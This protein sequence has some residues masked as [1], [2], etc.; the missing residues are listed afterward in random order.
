MAGGACDVS[1]WRE[2]NHEVGFIVKRGRRL[3]TIEAKSGR[4]PQAHRG[5]GAFTQ[6]FKVHRTLLVGGDG[7]SVED[8]LLEP[9]SHW[10]GPCIAEAVGAP[11]EATPQLGD[12]VTRIC[13]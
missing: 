1:C 2:R 11:I 9:V 5:T 4:A 6:S 13:P 12:V 8:F 7:V 10:L 3:V